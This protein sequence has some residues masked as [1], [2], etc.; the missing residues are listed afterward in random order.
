RFVNRV[1]ESASVSNTTK[2]IKSQPE[3]GN[4][5]SAK[6]QRNAWGD[7]SY[8]DLIT[9]A[10]MSSP[11]MKMSLQEIY[12]WIG[13]NIPYFMDKKG[14]LTTTGWKNSVRHTLSIRK[15]FIR[16]PNT[17][18]GNLNY[19]SHWTIDT[20]AASRKQQNRVGTNGGYSMAFHDTKW[21]HHVDSWHHSAQHVVCPYCSNI[22]VIYPG[23][24]YYQNSHHGN[25]ESVY[26]QNSRHGNDE[27]VYQQNS[28]HGN[29]ESVYQQNSRHGNDESVY[30]QNSHHGN[31]ESVYQQN[32]RHDN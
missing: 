18:F 24:L 12:Q 7:F 31:D 2:A 11:H 17:A 32:S 23:G 19:K 3:E 21:K 13:D 15:K 14:G 1:Q 4:G 16:L 26:Q 29:D 30:R 25:G 9:Q 22:A 10:I 6:T 28:R 27:S 20:H 8:S 5:K